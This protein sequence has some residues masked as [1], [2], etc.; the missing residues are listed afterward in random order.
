MSDFAKGLQSAVT[1]S[2]KFI[3]RNLSRFAT[4]TKSKANELGDLKK[5]RE[6]INHLGESIYTAS[7]AGFA[8]PE[9]AAEF[10]RQIAA[11]DADLESIRTAR[12]EQK[13]A[14]AQKVAEEK[15]L[16]AAEKAA[17][18]AAAAIEKSTEAANISFPESV[19]SEAPAVKPTANVS[20][21]E[22]AA[23]PDDTDAEKN[24]YPDVPTL[25]V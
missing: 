3:G 24:S 8:L 14:Y 7:K 1:R 16:R 10:A 21:N 11:L 20:S 6:L 23:A 19:I 5:R 25:N 18:K 2:I 15:A 9:D 22:D 13:A 12:A 17:A 4:A